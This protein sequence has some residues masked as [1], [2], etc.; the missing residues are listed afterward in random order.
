MNTPVVTKFALLFIVLL[1]LTACGGSGSDSS[2]ATPGTQSRNISG[3]GVKGPLADAVVTVYAF[4]PTKAGFKGTIAATASTNT[5]AAITGLALP[6]PVSPPY[7]MEFTSDAG[8]T[9][10]TTGMAPVIATMRTVITQSLL[11]SA[12]QIYATPLTTMAVDIAIANSTTTST[13][14]QFEAALAVAATQ[15]V[16]TVG[17]GMPADVNIFDV[18]PL[19]DS[20]TDTTA[21]Q[22]DVA[23]YRSAVEALT[24]VVFQMA[25]QS[26][27]GD[28]DA[29]LSELS[30]D[31]ADGEIDGTVASAPSTIFTSTSLD[32]LAQ[33]PAS[34]PIPNSPTGQTVAD[35]QAILV[36]ETATTGS[37]TSTTELAGGGSITTTTEPAETNP[38]IDNDGVLNV[39]DAFPVDP[40]ETIDTDGDGIG[41]NDDP[42]DDNNGILDVDEGLNP[43]PAATD[44][45]LDGVDDSVDNCPADYNPT[46]TN[47]DT[48]ADGGD[49]CDSD[50]DEDGTPDNADLFPLDI[51]EQS[52]ADGDGVGNNADT[53]D[54][55][56]GISDTVEDGS[57][58]SIDHD[59]DG[60]PNREDTDS[61]NDSVFDSVDFAPY[62][63]TITFNNAPVTADS[64]VATDED[65]AVAILLDVSD[66]G[67]A[68]GS[69]I[70]S[71]TGPSNGALTGT[72]PNLTYTPNGNYSGGDS[73]GF[74]ATDGDGEVSSVS[75]VTITVN[76]VNDVPVVD[77]VG[78]FGIA[79]N[80]VNGSAVGAVTATDVDSAITGFSIT[81]GNTGLAF[82]IS[83]GGAI[84]VADT[85]AVDFET[86]TSFALTVTATDGTDTSAGQVVTINVS[87]VNDT[88]PV[89]DAVG[90]FTL[91]ENSANSTVVGTV[92]ATDLDS[93]VVGYSI[94]GG[95]TG[96]AFAIAADGAI[97]VINSAA[98]DR[99]IITSFTLSITATDG[100]GTSAAQDV[101]VNLTDLN[102]TA[103][104]VAGAQSFVIS[105][106][107]INTAVVGTVSASDVDTVGAITGFTISGGNIGSAFSIDA[108]GVITVADTAAINFETS[109]SFTLSITATDGTNTSAAANVTINI[110]DANDTAPV[111]AGAQAFAV[112]EDATNTTV[113]G[114]VSASDVD[115]AGSITSF[116]IAGGNTG[117]AF[118][119]DA[120][121]VIT[122]ANTS[123]ID[124]ET[125]TSFTLSVTATDGI[126]TSSA[127]N[128]TVDIDDANDTAPIVAAAQSFTV[129]EDAGNT[130]VVG[131]V[132]AS[133]VDSVGVIT[134][135]TIAGGNSGG[136]FAIDAGGVITVAN[137]SAIDFETSISFTLSVTATDG[138]NTSAAE[139][140][141]IDIGDV[142]DTAPIVGAVGPFA[143]A[144][145]SASSA[146]VGT[147]TAT[148]VD[149]PVTGYSIVGGNTGTAFAIAAN[150]AITVANS[151]ALDRETNTSFTLSVTATDGI[152]TS[153]G[154]N[155]VINLTD[156]N[157]NAPVVAASQS[158]SVSSTAANST[159]VG[160]VIA[161]DADTT[162]VIGFNITSGNTGSAFSIAANGQIT[163]TDNT[164]LLANSPY[165]LT[166]TATDGSN[167]SATE[168]VGI[169]VT[170]GG[171]VWDGFNWDDG[172]T[173]Q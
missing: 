18:P 5:A 163:V 146:A 6:F 47:T 98:L 84:T 48:L 56:D 69:L 33:D 85:T 100:P 145:N 88:A 119:I 29:I 54:D 1:G 128:V 137:T 97:T 168:T 156:L 74:S 103:P 11:D 159:V 91:A 50:D 169:T 15:V 51:A 71:I 82:A 164:N 73:I 9:D 17:F 132:S 104:V 8:T 14:P 44:A 42:D 19:I 155:V 26:T 22:A 53:D 23:A 127:E 114:T 152:N 31:L 25:Q 144:E 109:T 149:S 123:A 130:T 36:S 171:A 150:G 90:P 92:T 58:A 20:T 153:N 16:S 68:A 166:I 52:D 105:E 173:W 157:D 2:P 118:A 120:G 172:S 161:S 10:I 7:I 135:F 41:D 37:T 72:A 143:L 61:D 170:T 57:G 138:I 32:I 34:L 4:D 115:T 141:T 76:S 63:D 49:V 147:V 140:V 134:N 35:V 3:G 38:D 80:A 64:S 28:Q 70:Y 117:N 167:T 148:D 142:N 124:Y 89:I 122:V 113:V 83:A 45:D 55:N 59:G 67:V 12:E 46:Q 151:A 30:L 93:P 60:T 125:S 66:D 27:G 108:G 24:A 126:N 107:A 40:S 121:G 101:V 106:D 75:T 139:N 21:E 99:E 86:A 96:T 87:D 62:D 110:N 129:L 94:V 154:Q 136:A 79:E 102:D 160:T 131:S 95:N 165:T 133:D 39:D 78:P 112:S 13:A 158:F 111:V 116:T 81:G 43:T 77:A 65:V 162:P